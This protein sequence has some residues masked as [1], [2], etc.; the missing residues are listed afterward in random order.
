MPHT[1]DA[2]MQQCIDDCLDCYQT[3]FSEAMSHCLEMGGKHVAAQHFGLM[4]NCAEL[5]RTTAEFMMSNSALHA[6]VCAA[7]AEVC[8]ACAESCL[9][10]GDMEVCI[11]ACRTCASSCRNMADTGATAQG[12]AGSVP[13]AQS[14]TSAASVKAPM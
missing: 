10:T 11:K 2:T 9:Q 4:I 1:L 3:C 5:C 13:G 7:C 6:R 14:Q 12:L 8:D